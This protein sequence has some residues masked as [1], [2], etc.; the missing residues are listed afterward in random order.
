MRRILRSRETRFVPEQQTLPV[1]QAFGPAVTW[2]ASASAMSQE[3]GKG[4]GY[5]CSAF[6]LTVYLASWSSAVSPCISSTLCQLESGLYSFMLLARASVFF[7]R[8]FSY[9]APS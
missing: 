9:T 3:F 7:P 4:S 5:D 6:A 2:M 1:P 8:S